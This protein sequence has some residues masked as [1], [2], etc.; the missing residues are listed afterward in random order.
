MMA[1]DG[2][3]Y[4]QIV[5]RMIKALAEIRRVLK[6]GGILMAPTFTAADSV[7]GRIKI[8][9]MELSGFKVFHKWTPEGYLDFLK[10]NGFE[11]TCV[12]TFD[13]GL[14]LTYAEAR[15]KNDV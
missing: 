11:I 8:R 6:T 5:S 4:A 15:R 9:L 12:K 10:A 14:K 7:S 2:K 1:K 3:T 13:G